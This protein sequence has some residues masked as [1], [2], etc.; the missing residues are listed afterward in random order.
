MPVQARVTVTPVW[1]A[2]PLERVI[3]PLS[4]APTGVIATVVAPAVVSST[5]SA[6]FKVLIV[7]VPALP[8]VRVLVIPEQ[9]KA[10]VEPA[11]APAESTMVNKSDAEAAVLAKTEG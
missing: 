1:P 11:G 8:T 10:K 9:V 2:E 3:A 6:E 4:M 5:A 7:V